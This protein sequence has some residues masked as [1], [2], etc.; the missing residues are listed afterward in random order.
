MQTNSLP[1]KN[2]M[3]FK[4]NNNPYHDRQ[5][6]SLE[7][8]L[9]LRNIYNRLIPDLKQIVDECFFKPDELLKAE[10]WKDFIIFENF[11]NR[12][13]ADWSLSQ[14]SKGFEIALADDDYDLGSVL[15]RV[16][17][18]KNINLNTE[19]KF[20]STE[21]LGK[22]E[23]SLLNLLH[24]AIS[25]HSNDFLK[26]LIES[27]LFDLNSKTSSRGLL[28][29]YDDL[30]PLH[31]AA[32]KLNVKALKMLLNMP[33]IDVLAKDREGFRAFDRVLMHYYS[34]K[35]LPNPRTFDQMLIVQK[36]KKL[37]L[38]A[39]GLFTDILSNNP[40][41]FCNS[42]NLLSA[43]QNELDDFALTA[44][45]SG[46]IENINFQK[47]SYDETPL[48]ASI[49]NNL[50][51][52][53]IKALINHPKINI[54][55]RSLYAGSKI[56]TLHLAV[57]LNNLNAI[58]LLVSHPSIEIDKEEETLSRYTRIDATPLFTA[59]RLNRIDA[60]RL[61]LNKPS[62]FKSSYICRDKSFPKDG[63]EKFYFLSPFE[64]AQKNNNEDIL[65]ML[66][67]AYEK[68]NKTQES[69]CYIQ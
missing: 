45:H 58:N 5:N 41:E 22:T 63:M 6:D 65:T 67:E 43:C 62:E 42:F 10:Q 24:R 34:I 56:T 2:E 64:M 51:P 50:T 21:R 40:K 39:I 23:C 31:I 30:T 59:V 44:I 25:A 16:S 19:I 11:N 46:H 57:I 60:V 38:E 7:E 3:D 28:K 14:I 8:Y 1:I 48:F 66:N 20:Y 47:K 68:K 26:A 13:I 37:Q 4:F 61:L 27:N 18:I 12:N 55:M 29:N 33:Q 17:Q 52:L 69:H 32:V 49:R 53:I 9:E 35:D 36:N 15:A 54:N